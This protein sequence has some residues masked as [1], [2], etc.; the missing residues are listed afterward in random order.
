MDEYTVLPKPAQPSTGTSANS[1]DNTATTTTNTTTKRP[2]TASWLRYSL[3]QKVTP[4]LRR[5]FLEHY[6][7]PAQLAQIIGS[8]NPTIQTDDPLFNKSATNALG[9][10]YS[11]NVNDKFEQAMHWQERSPNHHIIGLDHP[12]YPKRLLATKNVPPVL[13]V[14]GKQ[15]C[16]N[17]PSIAIVGARKASHHALEQAHLIAHELASI[18]ITI[19]SGLALGI[20]SA[21]HR[22]AIQGGGDTIAVAATGADQVYPRS[23]LKLAKRIQQNGA[24]VT[25]F[26]LHNPLR[27]HCFPRRNRIISGLCIGV[28]VI[29]AGL[30]SGTLTTAQ[31]AL[32]QGRE[33][34]AMPGSVHNPLT[35]GC[36]ELI[37]SGAALIENTDDVLACL[38]TELER[39]LSDNHFN[40]RGTT[41]P[42]FESILPE[43]TP[44]ALTLLD[45]LGA[46]SASAD[47]LINRSGLSAAAVAGAL[48]YLE[49]SGVIVSE[50]GG[51]YTRCKHSGTTVS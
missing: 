27:P 48:T 15:D 44:D 2:D 42:L 10:Q 40:S 30:P 9:F 46:D 29:E 45:C 7:T 4:A 23:H 38:K 21:A 49:I 37:K 14:N 35:R 41:A 43:I 8:E 1:A 26:P 36:H 32:R 18:G 5:Q 50:H 13:Y 6:P 16:L 31:H 34:M 51:R 3:N 12:D 17:Y 11:T 19:V 33:V 20:D 28:L 25:E 39:Q 22:G 47:T 24:I